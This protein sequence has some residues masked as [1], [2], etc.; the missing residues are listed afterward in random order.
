MC[1][2]EG[3]KGAIVYIQG[4]IGGSRVMVVN[5]LGRVGGAKV[6]VWGCM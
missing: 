2:S 4:R 6:M 3:V 5:S 1:E